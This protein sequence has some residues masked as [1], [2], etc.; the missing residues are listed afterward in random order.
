MPVGTVPCCVP[1]ISAAY[2]IGNVSRILVRMAQ[3]CR[4]IGQSLKVS[5]EGGYT[6]P[7][8]SL[9]ECST[10]AL[11]LIHVREECSMCAEVMSLR[12]V[13]IGIGSK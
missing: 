11:P 9:L 7:C 5:P 13:R 4:F 8:S 6:F 3:S 10:S 12:G 1:R 2:L